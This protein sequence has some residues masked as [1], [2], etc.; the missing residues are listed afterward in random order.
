MFCVLFCF[1]VVLFCCTQLIL[2]TVWYVFVLCCV[3]LVILLIAP[4]SYSYSYYSCSL[5]ILV[6]A[7]LCQFVFE[8]CP[9]S[10]CPAL[11]VKWPVCFPCG[12]VFDCLLYFII[13]KALFPPV[14]DS[15]LHPHLTESL[16]GGSCRLNK[17]L[18]CSENHRNNEVC[19]QVPS[20]AL[21]GRCSYGFAC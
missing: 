20:E 4:Y 5:F 14:I 16:S 15:S 10:S 2:L 8:C 12:V 21:G 6:F 3:C 7:V 17:D 1:S 9:C 13:I 19:Y 18:Q 11:S